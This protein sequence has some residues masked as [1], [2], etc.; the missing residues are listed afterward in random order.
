MSKFSPA[1]TIHDVTIAKLKET[2]EFCYSSFGISSK[3]TDKFF[4]VLKSDLAIKHKNLKWLFGDKLRIE[5]VPEVSDII[6]VAKQGSHHRVFDELMSRLNSGEF[7]IT[8][9]QLVNGRCMFKK[10]E[11]RITRI[12]DKINDSA[13]ALENISLDSVANDVIR[14]QSSLKQTT[15]DNDNTI[16]S[17]GSVVSNFSFNTRAERLSASYI[18]EIT[19]DGILYNFGG[20]LGVVF[21]PAE[22][23]NVTIKTTLSPQNVEAF[24]NSLKASSIFISMEPA[25]IILAA[26]SSG[27][28]SC[29]Q[30][31]S[32]HHLGN[33]ANLRSDFSLILYTAKG[34]DGEKRYTKT[35]RQWLWAPLTT[36]GVLAKNPHF[37]F[38]RTYG[39]I[40]STHVEV[41]RKFIEKKLKEAFGKSLNFVNANRSI[42]KEHCSVAY[43]KN[44]GYLDAH[45]DNASPWLTTSSMQEVSLNNV[46]FDHPLPIW[47]DGEEVSHGGIAP[48]SGSSMVIP[49]DIP[50]VTDIHGNIQLLRDVVELPSGEFIHIDDLVKN[51]SG[52]K[53]EQPTP[54]DTKP[55]EVSTDDV[56]KVSLDDVDVD[57]DF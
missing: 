23:L 4:R 41:A 50:E 34:A 15:V 55:V 9:E 37:K 27:V 2:I 56:I 52:V 39:A 1:E 5:L 24:L 44:V 38:Q 17:R 45:T 31:T 3:F 28:T 11:T 33:I 13:P 35:G 36:Q 16:Y 48:G 7:S 46:Y 43:A 29:H 26:Q 21:I 22:A 14:I 51:F 6:K 42:R 20:M 57:D 19:P 32:G 12:L 49:K 53:E 18:L 25:D 8:H 10:Q 30:I 54:E 40:N 47:F